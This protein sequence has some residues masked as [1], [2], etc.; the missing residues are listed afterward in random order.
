[1]LKYLRCCWTGRRSPVED[2]NRRGVCFR[3]VCQ[4]VNAAPYTAA[5]PCLV[6][7]FALNAHA[8]K[9]KFV[10]SQEQNRINIVKFLTCL[11]HA[12]S[13]FKYLIDFLLLKY[14]T[15]G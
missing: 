10:T 13:F 4:V 15:I 14:T 1:M 2:R 9:L 6:T 7:E 3:T 5:C 11:K 8:V 12:I